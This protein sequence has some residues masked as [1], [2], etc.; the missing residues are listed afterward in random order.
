MRQREPGRR[1]FL[2]HSSSEQ[3]YRKDLQSRG[4]FD[5][6]YTSG[7]LGIACVNGLLREKPCMRTPLGKADFKLLLL[8][9]DSDETMDGGGSVCRR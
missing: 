3:V 7:G 2:I 4:S 1:L 5:R 8:K 6:I 9:K